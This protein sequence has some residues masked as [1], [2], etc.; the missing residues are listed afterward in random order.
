[1]IELFTVWQAVTLQQR[2]KKQINEKRC[3]LIWAIQFVALS[4][5]GWSCLH[6]DRWYSILLQ[7][8]G[9]QIELRVPFPPRGR[10]PL[11]H[12]YRRR[13]SSFIHT[14]PHNWSALPTM[15]Q[16]VRLLFQRLCCVLHPPPARRSALLCWIIQIDPSIFDCVV[17]FVG[18][19]SPPQA[20]TSSP[21]LTLMKDSFLLD[22]KKFKK[23]VQPSLPKY[24]QPRNS[25]LLSLSLSGQGRQC[26]VSL[27]T[28]DWSPFWSLHRQLGW[29]W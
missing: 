26:P 3:H 15:L 27:S 13:L 28:R 25:F 8:D 21:H 4:S 7:D 23:K 19:Y 16:T 11:F 24:L 5:S 10:L 6:A 22:G 12:Q 14:Q 17:V 9:S 18:C 29:V 1:M 2:L 20:N